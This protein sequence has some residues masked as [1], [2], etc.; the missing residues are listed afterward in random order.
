MP[1]KTKSPSASLPPKSLFS[2][3]TPKKLKSSKPLNREL[4]PSVTSFPPKLHQKF[5]L[6]ISASGTKY[7]HY[8]SSMAILALSYTGWISSLINIDEVLDVSMYVYPVE[9]T[10]VMKN[11]RKKS[12]SSKL[13]TKST[14]NVA[15]SAIQ[16]S[17][18]PSTTP[19]N[20]ATNSRSVP[21]NSSAL[22][23]ISLYGQLP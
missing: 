8:L 5:T 3:N 11:L 13:A 20:S 2:P 22:V 16:K 14:P 18:P 12:P 17:K 9:T 21:K 4:P 10:V 15:K 19:R 1:R 23:S 6:A 7:G